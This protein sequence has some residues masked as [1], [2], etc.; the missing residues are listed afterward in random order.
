MEMD[1]TKYGYAIIPLTEIGEYNKLFR[2]Y[3]GKLFP[4]PFSLSLSRA[5]FYKYKYLF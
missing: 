5:F 1:N 3:L 4:L 2:S